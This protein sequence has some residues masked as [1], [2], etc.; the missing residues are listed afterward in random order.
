MEARFVEKELTATWL[1]TRPAD[2]HKGT[3][4]KVYIVGGSVGFSGAPLFAANGAIRS[5]SGLVFLG[6][7]ESIYTITALRCMEV[8]PSPLPD[9]EGHLSLAALPDIK[10]RI[11][12][13]D[14]ALLGPG[15]GRTAELSA[16]VSTL[17]R[18]TETPLVL[19]ADALYA[20]KDQKE[21]LKERAEKGKITILTPHEGEFAYLGGELSEGR[22][23]GARRFAEQYGC[24]VVLKGSGT[25]T[26]APDGTCF[27]NTTGNN[28]MAKGGS[29]DVLGG[30]LASLLGQGMEPVKAAALAVW[31]HGR[32]GDICREKLGEFSMLPS[33]LLT[34][35]PAAFCELS[36]LKRKIFFHKK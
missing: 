29:G 6:V 5:G 13:C 34:H 19:D 23:E 24:V 35:L 36:E 14:A 32:A 33:D 18:E 26:A 8:M 31:L 21:L 10:E 4:G 16:L 7:P 9:C 2:G 12:A 11:E 20:I 27:I 30:M 22:E 28:G 25:I 17:L 15:L 3:F 1:P